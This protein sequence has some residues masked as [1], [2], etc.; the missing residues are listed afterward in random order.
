MFYVHQINVQSI[1][2]HCSK[3]GNLL[4]KPFNLATQATST[5]EKEETQ[6]LHLPSTQH[7]DKFV[8]FRLS[9]DILELITA[10]Q[11]RLGTSSYFNFE[12]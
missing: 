6:L 3:L 4:L 9:F 11:L 8:I 12:R 7:E 5:S 2:F 1:L 10:D